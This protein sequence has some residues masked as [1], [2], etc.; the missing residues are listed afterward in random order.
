MGADR[1]IHVEIPAD[2]MGTCQP[3]HIA[4]IFA[5]LAE[6]EKADIIMLGKLAIDDDSNQ[7]A[8]MTASFLNWPQV[9]RIIVLV[10]ELKF[11][12]FRVFLHPKLIKLTLV[13]RL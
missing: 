8:Q 9:G 5:K 1:G 6:Q 3:I 11:I 13:L 2:Q 7:A 10:Y 4:K 12:C